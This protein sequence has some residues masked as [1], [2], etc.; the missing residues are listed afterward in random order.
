M[1]EQ[2][3]QLWLRVVSFIDGDKMK[4]QRWI[5][6]LSIILCCVC[7]GLS[8]AGRSSHPSAAEK[9][10]TP[11]NT[12][13]SS[14]KDV[15]VL[16]HGRFKKI[17]VYRPKGVPKS[18]VLL[19]SGND[20][21]NSGG[22]HM[23]RALVEQGALVAGI[24]TPM[25]LSSFEKE[26][27]QCVYPDGDLENL[28]HWVQAYYHLPTYRCPILVGYL[29][30]AT[31]AYAMMAQAPQNTF[32]GALTLGFSPYLNLRVPL[33]KGSG[34]E[35]KKSV[36][37]RGV[38]LMPAKNLC[39]RWITL[40]GDAD[41]ICPP[42]SIED[43]V[44][45]VPGAAIVIFPNVGKDYSKTPAWMS[46]FKGAFDELVTQNPAEE[47]PLPPSELGNLPIIEVPATPGLPESDLFAVLL[48][49]DGGWAGLDQ[50]VA[51]ALATK[52]LP[53]VGLDS[54]RYFWTPRTPDEVAVDVDRLIRYYLVHFH[55]KR[56]LLIGYSQGADVL[57]FV[58]NRLP[59]TT[60]ARVAVCAFMG[61][62]DQAAFE[63]HLSNWVTDAD[64]LPTM[65]EMEKISGMRLL[66]IYGEDETDSIC[67]KLDRKKIHVVETKG[68]HHF[69]G[70]YD[71]LTQAIL[72]EVN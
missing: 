48:S 41:P 71:Q 18:F 39:G 2:P 15:E 53:V 6:R 47:L 61:I 60:R 5:K 12:E 56:T 40:Q 35:F 38:M 20:G 14:A 45:K 23:A 10:I 28:S 58:I 7:L 27:G 22:I 3:L 13:T 25:L 24:H 42:R 46:Q 68:G 69:G 52:G 37:G 30:G 36:D 43:F 66:C 26:D 9:N 72:S 55:K 57:P 29:S 31:L 63:F 65:P 11:Q 64:G 49:G 19:L 33:C 51:R 59:D 34:I 8:L 4:K 1:K 70:D 50:E 54:L 44:S 21:W 67:F 16:S 62:S 17:R 32:A